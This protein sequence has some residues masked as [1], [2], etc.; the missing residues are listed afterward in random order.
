MGKKPKNKNSFDP[1][2]LKMYMTGAA[3]PRNYPKINY[4]HEVVDLHLDHLQAGN[5]KIPPQDA[6]FIQLQECEKAIDRAIAAGKLELRVIHG[7]GKGKLKEAI[8]QLL[9]KHPQ[10]KS[11]ENSY[12]SK[13]GYGS[14]VIYFY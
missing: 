14:T 7:L 5:H 3:N 2:V 10:V 8:H 9:D 6:L 12:H 13:Y 1:E 4:A 11:Y